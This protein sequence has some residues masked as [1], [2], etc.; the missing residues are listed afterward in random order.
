MAMIVSSESQCGNFDDYFVKK[1]RRSVFSKLLMIY[2]M[3]FTSAK[4]L[5]SFSEA[6]LKRLP[7]AT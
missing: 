2:Y 6:T 5:S 7:T 1:G 4:G 3:N